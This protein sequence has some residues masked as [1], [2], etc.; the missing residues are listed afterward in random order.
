MSAQARC[1]RFRDYL[2]VMAQGCLFQDVILHF[3]SVAC[4]LCFSVRGGRQFFNAPNKSLC[5]LRAEEECV[6][7]EGGLSQPCSGKGKRG[8][9]N[10]MSQLLKFITNNN[11]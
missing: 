7:V 3:A 5:V 1:E 9:L 8:N 4:A 11:T 10:Q 6:G 2:T